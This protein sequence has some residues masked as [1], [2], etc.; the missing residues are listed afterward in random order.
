MALPQ[1]ENRPR[2]ILACSSEAVE[3]LTPHIGSLVLYFGDDGRNTAILLSARQS[4]P[5]ASLVLLD[6]GGV[7]HGLDW[8]LIHDLQIVRGPL[9]EEYEVE[10]P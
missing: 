5:Y 1:P 3:W 6:S 4:Q 9:G 2:H 8:D 7:E 10:Q